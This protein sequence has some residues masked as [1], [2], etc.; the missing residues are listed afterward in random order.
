MVWRET[1]ITKNAVSGTTQKII[2]SYVN[3][4]TL[5]TAVPDGKI[6]AVPFFAVSCG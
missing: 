1:P 4:T 3:V 2:N 6:L 5:P